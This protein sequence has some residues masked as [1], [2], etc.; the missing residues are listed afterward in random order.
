MIEAL[1]AEVAELKRQLGMN[2]QNSS[3]P[4]STDSPFA[5]PG[6]EVVAA[7]ERPQTP[8]C[9]AGAGDRAPAD[10]APLRVW[11]DDLREARPVVKLRG[12]CAMS[13]RLSVLAKHRGA[14]DD[15]RPWHRLLQG[16]RETVLLARPGNQF[17]AH[18]AAPMR[19]PLDVLA[20]AFP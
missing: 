1:R 2:S 10:R 8:S 15:R 17:L 11:C 19:I 13:K 9:A 16:D 20:G 3:K 14:I 4:P 5:K 6:A 18:I 7:Q 12:T